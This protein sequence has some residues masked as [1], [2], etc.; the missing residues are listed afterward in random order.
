MLS[1][2][3]IQKNLHSWKRVDK[4]SVLICRRV[5]PQVLHIHMFYNF[6]LLWTFSYFSHSGILGFDSLFIDTF[7]FMGD[8]VLLFE[9][10]FSVHFVFLRL[11][12]LV[13][14][15]PNASRKNKTLNIIILVVRPC[16]CVFFI[17]EKWLD[18]F[19]DV[20]RH[21]FAKFHRS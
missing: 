10:S 9:R 16:N 2:C 1:R 8:P 21:K 15:S 18:R 20:L 7:S 12:V 17:T 4:F 3:K 14:S 19:K 5:F 13:D 6:S 11:Q